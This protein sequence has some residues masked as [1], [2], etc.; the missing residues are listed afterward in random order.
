MSR[1]GKSHTL[2]WRAMPCTQIKLTS[3]KQMS[4]LNVTSD[5]FINNVFEKI[6]RSEEE[7]YQT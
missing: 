5:Q 1:I 4:Y 7:A 6:P 3:I 2:Q